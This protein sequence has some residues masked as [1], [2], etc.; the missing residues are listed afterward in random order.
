MAHASNIKLEGVVERPI[1]SVTGVIP[2]GAN[3]GHLYRE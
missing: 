1:V 2:R 3:A